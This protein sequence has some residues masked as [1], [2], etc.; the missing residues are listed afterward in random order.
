M[1][2]PFTCSFTNFKP[3]TSRKTVQLVFEAPIEQL[4]PILT[5]LGNPTDSGGGLVA[6]ARLDTSKTDFN[7]ISSYVEAKPESY[8][9][10]LYQSY[11]MRNEKVAKYLSTP[12]EEI[13]V[14]TLQEREE[15]VKERIKK[16]LNID[17][18]SKLDTDTEAK[19]WF[20]SWAADCGLS[21][22]LPKEF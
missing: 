19:H 18:L 6:I 9:K 14:A 11:F 3:V 12:D 15:W 13:P 21:D 20:I 17:S 10:K 16:M 5:Y 2:Q 8:A 4:I 1:T 22:L 7:A